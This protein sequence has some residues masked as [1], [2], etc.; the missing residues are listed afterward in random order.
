M[1]IIQSN[2]DTAVYGCLPSSSGLQFASGT[3]PH[4][5]LETMTGIHVTLFDLVTMTDKMFSSSY[6]TASTHVIILAAV[7]D[8]LLQSTQSL[9]SVAA[10]FSALGHG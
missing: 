1:P 5:T 7:A 8:L 10:G 2:T 9:S 4:M 3:M 6:I